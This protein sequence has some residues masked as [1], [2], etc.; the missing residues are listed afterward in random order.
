VSKFLADKGFYIILILCIAAIGISGYVLFFSGSDTGD[1]TLYVG[2][3][4]V[5]TTNTAEP[6]ET[7]LQTAI[8]ENAVRETEVVMASPDTAGGDGSEPVS[9]GVSEG[10]LSESE[11]K[12]DSGETETAAKPKE[13]SA[14]KGNPVTAGFYVWPV[15]GEVLEK[16][17]V[18][19]LVF[20][21]TMSDWRVHPGADI[22]AS[23]GTQ[24]CAIGDGVVED[25]YTDEMMG[26]TI[27]I[28]HGNKTKSVYRNLMDGVTVASGDV[29]YAGDVIGGVGQS[30]ENELLQSPHLHLEVIRD[31]AQIDPIGILP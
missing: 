10:V 23:L 7:E 22:A 6:Q 14:P 28:D 19:E 24:V 5:E 30:A 21:E 4:E 13:S 27:V 1:D 8:P 16:F 25:V 18:D 20:N 31:G 15:N 29:V 26:V 2:D 3:N 9:G 11:S 17:S 12:G